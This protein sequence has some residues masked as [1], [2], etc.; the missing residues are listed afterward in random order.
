MIDKADAEETI[1]VLDWAEICSNENGC[2]SI[3]QAFLEEN[4]DVY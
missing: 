4:N 2:L 3:E 1:L